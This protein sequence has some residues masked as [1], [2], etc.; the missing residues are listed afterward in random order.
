MYSTLRK[1]MRTFK[2]FCSQFFLF[3]FFLFTKQHGK[4]EVEV[5]NEQIGS[6]FRKAWFLRNKGFVR[7]ALCFPIY[8]YYSQRVG[9]PGM[10]S[11]PTASPSLV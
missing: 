7:K 9:V 11:C 4:S 10:G 2:N 3:F 8:R 6:G 1:K 5:V